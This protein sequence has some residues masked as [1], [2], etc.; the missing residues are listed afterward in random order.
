MRIAAAIP[1]RDA[2]RLDAERSQVGED[3]LPVTRIPE[4]FGLQQQPGLR[5]RS[6]H[7][8]PEG[9]TLGG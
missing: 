9:Q 3:S 5:Q 7:L 2:L 8:G 4:L 6:Q 1:Q